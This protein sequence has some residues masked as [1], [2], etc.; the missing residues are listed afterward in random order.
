MDKNYL[1]QQINL[2]PFLQQLS[3]SIIYLRFSFSLFLWYDILGCPIN[4]FRRNDFN[5]LFLH[6]H[7]NLSISRLWHRFQFQ[8]S[9]KVCFVGDTVSFETFFCKSRSI[10]IAKG[11][12][13]A[14]IAL[15]KMIKQ[16]I[17]QTKFVLFM[18][19]MLQLLQPSA[20]EISFKRFGVGNFD[21]KDEGQ[22]T[23]IDL[24]KAMLVENPRYSV[25]ETWIFYQNVHRKHTWFKNNRS[26]TGHEVW[27][28]LEESS[29]VHL[30]GLERY[31]ELLSQSE[32]INST[33]YCNQLDKLK[34]VIAAKRPKLANWWG[35]N[36]AKLHVA[37]NVREKLFDYVGCST[38]LSPNFALLFVPIIKKFSSW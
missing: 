5:W 34:H 26:S 32:T 8:S 27:I 33:K 14:I 4:F 29:F 9:F 6:E 36:N 21:S 10:W 17:L 24:I 12:I 31:H 19:V 18:R 23:N 7:A 3:A 37:L 13:C 16:M 11:S 30:V 25:R 38:T 1:T 20:I 28:S 15:K 22:P 35:Y 2:N